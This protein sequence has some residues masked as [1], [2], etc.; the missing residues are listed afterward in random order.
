MELAP[1]VHRIDGI[2]GVNA[3]LVV[4]DDGLYVVDTGMPGNVDRIL[5]FIRRTGHEPGEV[6]E[7]VITH[8]D[9][10]HT[11]SA[12]RLKEA[13]GARIAI[14]AA[15]APALAGTPGVRAT[16]WAGAV[17]RA[18]ALL[19]RAPHAEPD[20]TLDEGD[21]VAGFR[22]LHVPGHTA[23]SI[24][25]HRDDGVVISGDALLSDS[26]GALELPRKALALDYERALASARRIRE[27]EPSLLLPGHGLPVRAERGSGE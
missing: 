11:G 26:K 16:G 2:G 18:A 24:A 5:A 15:D 4:A 21:T 27:L 7:I 13:T 25:L 19:I 22:V 12:V 17:F 8:S 9:P 10:D 3:Y 20:R 1:G 6:R 23:G 14:H